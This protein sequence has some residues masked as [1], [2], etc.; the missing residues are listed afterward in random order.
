MQGRPTTACTR[1]PAAR[2]F[3]HSLP[4]KMP[5][6]GV[7]LAGPAAGEAE[8]LGGMGVQGWKYDSD[9]STDSYQTTTLVCDF[10]HP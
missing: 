8:A 3:N 1:L 7:S 4:A 6:L 2:F 9:E 5:V 10:K